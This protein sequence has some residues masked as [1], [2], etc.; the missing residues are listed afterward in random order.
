M[1]MF[2]PQKQSSSPACQGLFPACHTPPLQRSSPGCYLLPQLGPLLPKLPQIRAPLPLNSKFPVSVGSPD[3]SHP[4]PRSSWVG[5][6]V[7]ISPAPQ[8]SPVVGATA[9][10]G[11]VP[12]APGRFAPRCV[13]GWAVIS[14]C[15]GR[16][17]PEIAPRVTSER[18]QLL[19]GGRTNKALYRQLMCPRLPALLRVWRRTGHVRRGQHARPVNGD[20]LPERSAR[21]RRTLSCLP[22]TGPL[23]EAAGAPDNPHPSPAMPGSCLPNHQMLTHFTPTA[24]TF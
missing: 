11:P 13:Y 18:A 3:P 16:T 14:L 2:C 24:L 22:F 10:R 19:H 6:F 23:W 7:P 17:V 8:R 9:A 5:E 12:L 15:S 1:F 20:T 4:P 21:R